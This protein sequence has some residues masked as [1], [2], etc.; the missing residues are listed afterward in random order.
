VSVLEGHALWA[1]TYDQA[2][3]PLL[4]LEERE[5]ESLLPDLRNKF[6]LDVAC[7]T[8][9]WL[10]KLKRQGARAGAGLDMSFEMLARASVKLSLRGGLIH[11]DA[12][13]LPIRSGVADLVV[14]S[15]A[16]G[17]VDN[18][19]AFASEL[20]R[21]T[22]PAGQIFVSDFHPANHSRGWRRAFRTG[23]EV[24]EICNIVRPLA[25]ICAEFETQGLKL[26]TSL[27]PCFDEPERTL[28]DRSGRG[29]FFEAAREGPAIFICCLRRV[30]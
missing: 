24:V 10:R 13:A 4:A 7:G 18:L 2:L 8:G 11:G 28:F 17:Y 15:F 6:V 14:C 12:C 9:R 23:G 27:E 30:L 1:P 3:N 25:Q 19:P 21:V 29:Q 20:A 26:E 16:V 22:R 5:L